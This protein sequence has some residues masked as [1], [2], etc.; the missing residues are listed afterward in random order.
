M[1][2]YTTPITTPSVNKEVRTNMISTSV[3]PLRF[4]DD[5]PCYCIWNNRAL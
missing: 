5:L 3:K 4:M 1:A 2:A